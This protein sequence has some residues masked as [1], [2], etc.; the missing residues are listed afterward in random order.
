[1]YFP[2]GLWYALHSLMGSLRDELLERLKRDAW[3]KGR[4]RLASGKESDFFIDCKAV[5]LTAD[6][7]RLLGAALCEALAREGDAIDGVA[8]VALGGCPLASAVSLT[9]ALQRLGR[10]GN[11]WNA[12][13]VRKEAKDHGTAK[14]VEGTITAP[15]GVDRPRVALLED[16]LTTGGSSK[17]A[18]ESLRAEG[19]DVVA[20]IALVD[21]EE[22][23]VD[24]LASVGVPARALLS[25]ADFFAE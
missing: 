12:L 2:R 1:M 24:A 19:Y 4:F 15:E 9:S 8:G 17:K 14:L 5:M 11:G 20:V 10:D 21:R 18:V 13:Y 23:A 16:V 6:G 22:G 25:R 7:H 3:K